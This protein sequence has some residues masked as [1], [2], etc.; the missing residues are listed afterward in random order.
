M[1]G[2]P[3]HISIEYLQINMAE[4]GGSKAEY[5]RT[6]KTMEQN[7]K[8]F[9]DQLDLISPEPRTLENLDI[10]SYF[11]EVTKISNKI[12][13][14]A[15]K[16][17][18][19]WLSPPVP[20]NKD[21]TQMGAALEVACV[22]LVAAVH[23]FP[24]NAGLNISQL[25]R[26][27]SR[28][29]LESCLSF[30]RSMTDTLG[31]KF[32][33]N[34]HPLLERFGVVTSH[35]D[36]LRTAPRSNKAVCL[37]KLKDQYGLLKDAL[38]ELD[39]VN[40]DDFLEDFGEESEK[41]TEKDHQLINPCKGLIKTSIFLVKKTMDTIRKDGLEKSCED[42]QEYDSVLES[43][44]KISPSVDDSALS[45]YPPL[46][47]SECKERNEILKSCLEESLS[48][49]ADF[50][51]MKSEDSIKWKDFVSKAV[52]HN[53]SEIQRVFITAGLAEMKVAE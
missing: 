29:V 7:I 14:E 31:K 17:S 46:D 25:Y 19:S 28:A 51:F 44:M 36:L 49:L 38:S 13:F 10:E 3:H 24:N 53:F 23:N 35:C 16:L 33:S 26:E 1:Y 50:H 6:L 8:N 22:A 11:E 32:S 37:A 39:E 12:S 43:I 40:N 18:L 21:L 5:K 4:L 47:W 52:V 9:T 42:L 20:S 48:R 27:R 30:V 2:S 41:W 34:S 15:N 45:L